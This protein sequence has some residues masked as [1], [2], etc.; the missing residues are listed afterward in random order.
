M[1]CV[2]AAG[3]K[4]SP[5]FI[6]KGKTSRSLHGFNTLA[7]PQGTR[8]HYQ[9]NGWMNDEIGERWFEDVFLMECGKERPQ[10]LILDGHSSHESLSI[11]ELAIQ[12][13]I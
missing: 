6:V 9:A 5:L 12:N 8:W 7:A 11:I 4:M 3:N 1:A 13:N 2:N 10:L